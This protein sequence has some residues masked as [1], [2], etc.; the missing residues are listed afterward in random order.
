[1]ITQTVDTT[2]QLTKTMLETA[3]KDYLMA[4][5]VAVPDSTTIEILLSGTPYT[6]AAGS[7]IAA[8]I[9]WAGQING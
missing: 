2:V 8:K 7:V 6:N 9:K 4:N 1:M 5:H 3:I